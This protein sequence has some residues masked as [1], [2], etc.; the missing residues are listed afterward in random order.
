[1]PE[2]NS[3][4]QGIDH[5]RDQKHGS[6]QNQNQLPV[7]GKDLQTA[8]RNRV[9]DQTENAERRT[10]D[11]P[12]HDGGDAVGKIRKDRSRLLSGFFQCQAE[13]HGPEEN[14]DVVAVDQ[15]IHR[16][17]NHTRQEVHEDLGHAGRRDIA[18]GGIHSVKRDGDGKGKVDEH[19]NHGRTERTE[20]IEENNGPE[21]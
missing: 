21:P 7:R 6:H 18:L 17:C 20:Q 1:M 13:D 19:R 12:A 11:D 9:K 16:V 5:Q 2:G 14:A 3:H 4:D 15:G 8:C 10:A